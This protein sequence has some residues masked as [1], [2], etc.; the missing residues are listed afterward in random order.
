LKELYFI[1]HGQTEWNAIRRMQGQWNSDLTELGREQADINGRFL[2]TLGIDYLVASPLDRT[3]QTADIINQ[4]LELDINYD[5]RIMEWHCGDWSGELWDDVSIKWP[6]EFAAW[7]EDQFNYPGPNGENYPDMIKR[8]SP[9]LDEVFA[10]QHSRIAIV[11][12]G[13]I[14][15]VMVSILLG[16]SPEEMFHFGQ[17][18]DTIFHLTEH[19]EGFAIQHFVGGEGPHSGLPPRHY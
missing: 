3:R 1:R 14:G 18:N 2:A 11:S 8:T 4:H 5:G 6:K 17:S 12:H 19:T 16:H 9:F 10:S 7:Q 13:M 15:R